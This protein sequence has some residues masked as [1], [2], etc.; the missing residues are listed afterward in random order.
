MTDVI[1]DIDLDNRNIID[2]IIEL[3]EIRASNTQYSKITIE[4]VVRSMPNALN[5]AG[6]DSWESYQIVGHGV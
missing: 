1:C 4:K 3:S 5:A 6:T 2:V